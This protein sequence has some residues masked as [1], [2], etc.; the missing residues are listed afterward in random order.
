M[1]RLYDQRYMMMMMMMTRV[2]FDLLDRVSPCL[3]SN[4]CLSGEV[5]GK[6]HSLAGN[7]SL[8]AGGITLDKLIQ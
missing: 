8:A 3:Q 6:A 4:P 2:C 5:C 7:N 1:Q